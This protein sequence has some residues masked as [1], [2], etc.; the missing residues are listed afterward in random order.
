MIGAL[1]LLLGCQL[2]GEVLARWFGWPVPGPV[3][4]M[5]GL[6]AWLG[7][8]DRIAEPLAQTADG[9][10]RHLSLLFVPAGV[11]AMVHVQRLGEEGVA[12]LAALA[13]STLATLLVAVA[14]FRMVARWTRADEPEPESGDA[15]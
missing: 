13:L 2:A 10:L 4:G 11:G 3:F 1:A 5:L 12:I 8:R 15:P 9:L 6:L 14:A 7:L